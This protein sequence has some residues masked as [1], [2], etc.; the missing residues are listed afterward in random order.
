MNLLGK[1]A[2]GLVVDVG[3]AA[4]FFIERISKYSPDCRFIC[5]EPFPGNWPFLEKAAAVHG[6]SQIIR[7]AV[8]EKA[9]TAS[10][11]I[12]SI[13]KPERKWVD[14]PGYSSPAGVTP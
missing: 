10:F 12:A 8:D 4:G 2:P 14:Y 11:F 7:S 5:F 1:L 13:A 9:G 3:A 6:K